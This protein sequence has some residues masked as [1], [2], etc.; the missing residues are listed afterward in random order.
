MKNQVINEWKRDHNDSFRNAQPCDAVRYTES[1]EMLFHVIAQ[2]VFRIEEA[3]DI[4]IIIIIAVVN[5]IFKK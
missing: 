4:F 5:S 2:N 3:D 1:K